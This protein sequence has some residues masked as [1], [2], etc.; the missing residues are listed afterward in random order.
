MDSK[1][2]D[3]QLKSSLENLEAPFD[4]TSWQALEN[5]MNSN[6]TEEQPAAVEPVDLVVKRS[7]ER[8]EVPYH[9]GDWSLLNARLNQRVLVRR[10]RLSKVAEAAIFLL[11]LINIEG[12]L[13]GFR[14]V[15]KPAVPVVPKSVVPMASNKHKSSSHK[16]TSAVAESTPT[17]LTA[18][19]EQMVALIAA[20]FEGSA[21]TGLI[22]TTSNKSTEIASITANTSLL[23]GANFYT[24]S[25][26]VPFHKIKLLPQT[27]PHEFAWENFLHTI[28]GV[29]IT[30]SPKKSNGFYAASFASFDKNNIRSSTLDVQ[31]NGFGGGAKIGYRKGKWGIESGLA[32]TQQTFSPAKFVDIYAGSPVLGFLGA[33]VKDVKA[34]IFSIPVK[35]TRQF[36]RMGKTTAH[37][38]AGITANIATEKQFAYK[39][40][41]YPPVGQQGPDLNPTPD[42]TRIS[43]T[44]STGLLEGG[45][46]RTNAYATADLG[47]RVER[48]IGKRYTAFIEP[49]YRHAMGGGVGPNREYVNTVSIQAGVMGAL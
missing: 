27:E 39:T 6:F 14:E 48:P 5:R 17:I 24:S 47:L 49:V 37:A 46:L 23:D 36:A 42:N 25:G 19:A 40:V 7:L 4:S 13:G 12:F 9:G 11:L 43:T 26:I 16:Q 38:V 30:P 34:D 32:Y 21:L 20:P 31:E 28:P 1:N 33:Y 45:S 15:L 44:N 18:M 29:I 35:V 10:I 41:Y 3:K 22:P 8:L 2:F